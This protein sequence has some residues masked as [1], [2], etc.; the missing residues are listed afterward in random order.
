[1]RL[2]DLDVVIARGAMAKNTEYSFL[3]GNT[4]I[5]TMVG[6]LT[7]FEADALVSSD[8]GFLSM[9]GGV[10]LA[11]SGVAGENLREDVR[12]QKVPVSLGSVVVTSAGRLPARYVFHAI[13]IDFTSHPPV[14]T[15]IACLM[16]SILEIGTALQIDHIA[17]P[18]L[19]AGTAQLPKEKVLEYI[20]QSAM[21]YLISQDFKL[22]R[23][24]VVMQDTTHMLPTLE[25]LQEKAAT[26]SAIQERINR[27][28][29]ICD[30]L[31]QDK[32]LHDILKTRI[33]DAVKELRG[34]FYFDAIDSHIDLKTQG[35]LSYDEYQDAKKRLNESV[36]KLKEEVE[37]KKKLQQIETRRCR[38]L[39]EQQATKGIGTS[40]EIAM[41]IQDI[42]KRCDQR[43]REVQQIEEKQRMYLQEM[44]SLRYV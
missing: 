12:K 16:R 34:I 6:D 42:Q 38:I 10:S 13:T 24:T 36:D 33:N 29:D 8:D 30:D 14:D 25:K 11:L 18:L 2:I 44:N 32:E 28:K 21:Y 40:P 9:G 41:E 39:E 26:A 37:T 20:L 3:M 43:N 22:Q 5:V 35:N 17:L 27:I 15:L 31:P 19:G 4:T 23:L 1:M 7:C